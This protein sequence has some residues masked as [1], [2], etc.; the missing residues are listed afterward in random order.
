MSGLKVTPEQLT[1]LSGSVSRVCGQVRA[2]HQGLRGQLSPLFGADWS[3]AAAAQF[4]ALFDEFDRSA[5]ALSDALQG[6]G[7]LLGR[8]GVTYREAEAA[9]AASFR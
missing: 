7:H 6:I 3:G 9:I 2:E 1:T 4:T 8:A 5:R